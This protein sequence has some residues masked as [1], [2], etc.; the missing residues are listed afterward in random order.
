MDGLNNYFDDLLS[1][2]AHDAT[3]SADQEIS[4]RSKPDYATPRVW[5][6]REQAA[7]LVAL[8]GRRILVPSSMVADRRAL[9][10]LDQEGG[11]WRPP[12]LGSCRFGG[13][14]TT[15]VAGTSIMVPTYLMSIGHRANEPDRLIVRLHDSHWAFTCH[16]I[17]DLG[18]VPRSSIKWRRHRVNNPVVVGVMTELNVPVVDIDTVLRILNESPLLGDTT[19]DGG[20]YRAAG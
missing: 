19:G 16:V 15:V 9:T 13:T 18:S 20:L 17:D 5:R 6:D 3:Y 1:S 14:L 2:F 10:A 7:S 11:A 12:L 4:T 8:G